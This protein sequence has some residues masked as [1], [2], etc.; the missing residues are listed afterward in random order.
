M[1]RISAFQ[2]HRIHQYTSPQY[3]PAPWVG[4]I[5]SGVPRYRVS[6]PAFPTFEISVG[7]FLHEDVA[8]PG[9]KD[10]VEQPLVWTTTY[11]N[12][13]P[14]GDLLHGTLAAPTCSLLAQVGITETHA[15]LPIVHGISVFPVHR[16]NQS[17][18]LQYSPAPWVCPICSGISRYTNS[19]PNVQIS[20]VSASPF[21]HEDLLSSG[22]KMGVEQRS[23]NSRRPPNFIPIQ[24]LLPGK[25]GAPS[26]SLLARAGITEMHHAVPIIDRSSS[27]QVRRIYQET[28]L[29]YAPDSW[30]PGH[31]SDTSRCRNSAPKSPNSE[32]SPSFCCPRQSH[33][34]PQ[35]E[36]LAISNLDQF[37]AL[38]P[39]VN[40]VCPYHLW[41]LH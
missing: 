30:V 19:A 11:Q 22:L 20:K 24:L 36:L 37:D 3:S 17:T 16:I 41:L 28:I 32:S 38:N 25:V 7:P 26:C 15:G 13:G 18:P 40:S 4:P 35:S 33:C 12:L 5:C 10:S 27:F 8:R 6:D 21:L 23:A 34:Q 39:P 1:H 31:C 9:H 29:Q 14:I 2:V